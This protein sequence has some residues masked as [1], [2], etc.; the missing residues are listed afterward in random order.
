MITVYKEELEQNLGQCQNLSSKVNKGAQN[1]KSVSGGW[2]LK[3]YWS[4]EPGKKDTS[5]VCSVANQP[6]CRTETESPA[7]KAGWWLPKGRGLGEEW[8]GRLRL[9]DV[10]FLCTEWINNKVL[11]YSTGNYIQYPMANQNV[12]EYVYN[13]VIS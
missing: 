4:L 9:A 13:R 12:K 7:Q 6:V 2:K 8:T 10:K 3:E 1:I 5:A 11:L